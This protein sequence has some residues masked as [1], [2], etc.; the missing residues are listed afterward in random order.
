MKKLLISVL[1]LAG[2]GLAPALA[3]AQC[4]KTTYYSGG[5]YVPPAPPPRTYTTYSTYTAPSYNYNSYKSSGYSPSAGY[6]PAKT[7]TPS[8]N[9]GR[10]YSSSG[11]S[12]KPEA[13]TSSQY[14]A[15][16]NTNFAARNW[17]AVKNMALAIT[18]SDLSDANK[19]QYYQQAIIA[20]YNL[21]QNDYAVGLYEAYRAFIAGGPAASRPAAPYRSAYSRSPSPSS[22]PSYTYSTSS[23]YLPYAAKPA[24]AAGLENRCHVNAAYAYYGQSK[25]QLALDAFAR[26]TK[27]EETDPLFRAICHYQLDNYTAALDILANYPARF[28][29]A[30]DFYYYLGT[31]QLH[32]PAT[33]AGQY[34]QQVRQAVASFT[35]YLGSN[36]DK[37]NAYLL[38]SKAYFNL[39]DYYNCISDATRQ[40]ELAHKNTGAL[41]YRATAASEL[42][43]YP[44]A[45]LDQSTLLGFD[46]SNAQFWNA[47]AWTR[48]LSGDYAGGLADAR[49]AL[50]RDS[51][52]AGAVNYLD[53]RGYA[54]FGLGQY[55]AADEDYTRVVA[56]NPA[57]GLAY[58]MRG[59][60]RL[61]LGQKALA[62]ADLQQAVKLGVSGHPTLKTADAQRLL[63]APAGKAPA[64]NASAR[65]APAKAPAR[66]AA[67]SANARQ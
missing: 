52:S 18:V 41:Y 64:R 33:G 63:A 1:V 60:T 22:S 9:S 57:S 19:P 31:C 35:S 51:T 66:K 14:L 50:R 67:A 20:G 61:K 21:R 37:S 24:A 28:S 58:L 45:L 59:R 3:S 25:Y 47:R 17:E 43:Q 39:G 12:A 29:K 5:S 23:S 34:E 11:Y 7:Y 65:K 38:R 30:A 62:R 53:T 16:M 10:S 8:Y 2:A 4:Y 32:A 6:A 54:R 27:P 49:E 44:A 36:A 42:K 56:L 40:L 55:P 15:D 48:C 46:G 13:R 26:D